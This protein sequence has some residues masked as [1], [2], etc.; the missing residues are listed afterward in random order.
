ME[1]RR[2]TQRPKKK[3]KKEA[4]WPKERVQQD[5]QRSTKQYT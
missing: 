2:N 1:E 5:K 4:Q 3:K